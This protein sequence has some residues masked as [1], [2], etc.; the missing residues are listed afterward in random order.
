MQKVDAPPPEYFPHLS[1]LGIL[2]LAPVFQQPKYL[3][4]LTLTTLFYLP[5]LPSFVSTDRGEEW[6]CSDLGSKL[7]EVLATHWC[8]TP[9][10]FV[11]LKHLSFD[12]DTNCSYEKPCSKLS[13]ALR[14]HLATVSCSLHGHGAVDRMTQPRI[15]NLYLLNSV[16][17][18]CHQ[19]GLLATAWPLCFRD[20]MLIPALAWF[21]LSVENLAV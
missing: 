18:F 4:A 19:P 1:L 5:Y 2:H 17:G 7:G 15:H 13:A 9:L 10:D 3:T 12:F 20:V 6:T 11:Y 16:L 8:L 14:P 21:P